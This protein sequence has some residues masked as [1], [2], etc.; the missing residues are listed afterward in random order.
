VRAQQAQAD[1]AARTARRQRTVL[2][3]PFIA[4]YEESVLATFD[5]ATFAA[6]LGPAA[7]VV[8]LLCVEREPAACHRSLLAAHLHAVLGA[9]VRHLTP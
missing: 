1:H 9:P 3:Q 2:S 5:A 7:H 6:A 8:A 4:G